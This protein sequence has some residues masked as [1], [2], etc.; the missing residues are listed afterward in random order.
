MNFSQKE[1]GRLAVPTVRDKMGEVGVN[2]KGETSHEGHDV[3]GVF[4]GHAEFCPLRMIY[5]SLRL[6]RV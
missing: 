6:V 5:L 2:D 3:R 1:N 4:G